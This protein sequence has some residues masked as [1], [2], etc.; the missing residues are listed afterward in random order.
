MRTTIKVGKA[1]IGQIPIDVRRKMG[2]K[3]GD[4]LM[5]EIEEIFKME[6]TA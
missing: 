4:I 5:V 3:E 2:V 1:G 6:A